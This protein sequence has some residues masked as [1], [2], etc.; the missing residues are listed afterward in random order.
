MAKAPGDRYQSA[1]EMQ[2]D[3]QRA[4]SGMQVAAMASPPT[5]ADYYD[6]DY[7]YDDY[8]QDRTQR[9]GQ[10]TAMSARQTYPPRAGGYGNGGG[11]PPEQKSWARRWLPWLIP[12]LVILA[13]VGVAG[14]MLLSSGKTY[15]VPSVDGSTQAQAV[16]ALRQAGF[17]NYTV[18][19]QANG[20]VPKGNVISTSPAGGSSVSST[21]TPVTIYVSSGQGQVAVPD[22]TNQ[23]QA[24]A[25]ATLQKAG[26]VVNAQPDP[27]STKAKGTVT[28]QDPAGGTQVAPGSTVTIKVSGGGVTVP[29]V[30]NSNYL[31]AQAQLQNLGL[32]VTVTP[33]ND[34]ASPPAGPGNVWQQSIQP[35]TVVAQGAAI[36]LTYEPAATPTPSASVSPSDT[37]TASATP[38]PTGTATQQ[39]NGHQ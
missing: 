32:V 38:T 21:A 16:A 5:R 30:L 1:A 33:G 19:P 7:D 22:V 15:Y 20:S 10:N 35:N 34:P 36:T 11:Y 4:A 23:D 9:M 31:A 37:G 18:V 2:A 12:A 25:T 26:L 3:V 17:T 27:T 24:A 6:R 13:V 14:S 39:G 28:S 29:S 8:P